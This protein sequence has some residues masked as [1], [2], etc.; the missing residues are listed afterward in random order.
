M[1]GGIVRDADPPIVSVAAGDTV[2]WTVGDTTF[3]KARYLMA[4]IEHDWL[5]GR[6]RAP[7]AA[8]FD[9]DTYNESVLPIVEADRHLFVDGTETLAKGLSLRSLPGH[10]PGQTGLV[11]DSSGAQAFFTGDALHFPM[12]IPLWH[13]PVIFDHNPAQGCE[14]RQQILEHCVEHD[15][16]L[17]PAHFPNPFGCR[18]RR[19]GDRF[20]A[21]FGLA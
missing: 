12:Q 15:A 1:L 10:T 13:W 16:L 20:E 5:A 17:L 7:G 4:E 21:D 11:L 3:P 9:A 8:A 14:T 2:R 6:A 19:R 18:I